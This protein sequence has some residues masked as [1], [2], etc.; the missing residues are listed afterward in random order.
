VGLGNEVKRHFLNRF[1]I[2]LPTKPFFIGFSVPIV[3]I[4]DS[5]PPAVRIEA[6]LGDQRM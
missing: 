5:P 2:K 6:L 3:L 4:G 1:S